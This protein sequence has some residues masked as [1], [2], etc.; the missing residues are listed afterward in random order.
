MLPRLLDWLARLGLPAAVMLAMLAAAATRSSTAATAELGFLALLAGAVLTPIG[1]SLA[2]GF[3]LPSAAAAAVVTSAW[4]LQ[5]PSL[6]A[7][8]IS[9]IL[10]VTTAASIGRRLSARS[11]LEPGVAVAAALC[12]QILFRSELLV[13]VAGHQAVLLELVGLPL[14][15]G[16]ATTLLAAAFGPFLAC[17]GAATVALL[18]GGWSWEGTLTLV[19]FAAAEHS[20][21]ADLRPLWRWTPLAIAFLIGFLMSTLWGLVLGLALFAYRSSEPRAA[22]G[23]VVPS[24]LAFLIVPLPARPWAEVIPGIAL[25]ALLLPALPLLV[26]PGGKGHATNTRHLALGTWQLVPIAGLLLVISLRTVPGIAAWMPPVLLLALHLRRRGAASLLQ[27][28]WTGVLLTSALALAAYPWL[29]N[30][31]AL[32]SLA[33]FG[34]TP[35]LLQALLVMTGFLATAAGASLLMLARPSIA[36]GVPLAVLGASALAA[37]LTAPPPGTVVPLKS[38]LTPAAPLAT[39][40]LEEPLEAHSITI[41]SNLSNGVGLMQGSAVATVRL[42]AADGSTLERVLRAGEDTAEWAARRPDVGPSLQH[43]PPPAWTSFVTAQRFF[44]Q[45]YRTTLALPGH[46]R[47]TNIEVERA[48]DLPFATHFS[49]LHLEIRP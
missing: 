12:I 14:A 20:R 2:Q 47:L 10:V 30:E 15:A 45:R 21:R 17:T 31:P 5:D 43:E 6:R 33:L 40:A 16:L 42:R 19:A 48:A 4:I 23:L 8:A 35:T 46:H 25:V 3:W 1:F 34:L 13:D 11:P 22:L 32:D 7:A 38:E 26:R 29:R 36:D 28:A 24:T 49:L 9:L 18:G 44:G 41:D 39:V 27:G 37:I